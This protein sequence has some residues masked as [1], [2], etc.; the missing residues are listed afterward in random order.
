MKKTFMA[1]L[2]AATALLSAC[3]GKGS[4]PEANLKT[5]V[6]SLSYMLGVANSPTDE[7]AKMY[8]MQAGSDSTYVEAFLKGLKDGINSSDDKKELAYQIGMQAGMQMKTRMFTGIEQQVFAGDST[9]HISTKQYLAGFLAAHTGNSGLYLDKEKKQPVTRETVQPLLKEVMDR[10]TSA[11]NEK[12]FGEAKKQNEAFIAKMAKEPGVKAL[13]GGVYY[14]EI[15]AGSGAKPRND[16]SVEVSYEG[17]LSNGTVFDSSQEGQPV[18]FACNQLIP[19]FT[20][21]LT[22]MQVGSEWEVY[23]PWNQAYGA[24]QS[25]PIPPYSALVFKIKLVKIKD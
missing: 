6:D 3:N 13:P 18:T 17:R 7:E 4:Q 10:M 1:A 14:K 12:V 20:T 25:G 15:V 9:K 21:A 11:A 23:I 24:Q 2:M 5:D 8:L 22:N 16:Q 19:G